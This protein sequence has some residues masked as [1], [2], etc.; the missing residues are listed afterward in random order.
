MIVMKAVIAASLL[1]LAATAAV[2]ATL[3][4]NAG[5]PPIQAPSGVEV[6]GPVASVHEAGRV[7][8]PTKQEEI[9]AEMLAATLSGQTE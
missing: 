2:A 5:G 1:A 9:N 6:K 3:P 8:K 4:N 7:I